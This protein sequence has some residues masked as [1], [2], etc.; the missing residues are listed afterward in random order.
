[1]PL[2]L[3]VS[4]SLVAAGCSAATVGLLFPW[5]LSRLG[6]DPAYGSGPLATIFQDVFSLLVYF[7][8]ITLF[9]F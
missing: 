9:L 6:K 4:V 5:F 3:A 8:T 1:L 2:A 7:G